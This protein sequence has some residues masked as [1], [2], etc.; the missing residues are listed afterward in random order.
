MR[1]LSRRLGCEGADRGA[2]A[3]SSARPSHC[4]LADL[5]GGDASIGIGID[6]GELIAGYMGSSRTMNYT[7]IGPPVNLAS[8]LC[9]AAK[10]TQ[11]LISDNTLAAVGSRVQIDT[12][13]PVELKGI[14]S[15]APHNVIGLLDVR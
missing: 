8:R 4:Q 7:V 6:T 14:G 3:G 1:V 9:G 12:L 13:E 10:A 2:R 5:R 11:I 15:V